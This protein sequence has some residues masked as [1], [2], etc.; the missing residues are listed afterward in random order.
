MAEHAK[1]REPWHKQFMVRIAIIIALLLLLL[2]TCMVQENEPENALLQHLIDARDSFAIPGE[3]VS[4]AAARLETVEAITAFMHEQM[5][6]ATYPERLYTPQDA[7]SLRMASDTDAAVLLYAL[8]SE[9]GHEATLGLSST[10]DTDPTGW[11]TGQPLTDAYQALGDY[12]EADLEDSASATAQ[13]TSAI[14]T[15]QTAMEAGI[16]VA[17]SHSSA[18]GLDLTIA[19]RP[20]A[21]GPRPVVMLEDGRIFRSNGTDITDT[22]DASTITP[23]DPEAVNLL[24]ME[25]WMRTADGRTETLAQWSSSAANNTQ[26]SFQPLTGA[27]TFWAGTFD[28]DTESPALWVPIIQSG[29]EA[30]EGVPFDIGNGAVADLSRSAYA[31]SEPVDVGPAPTVEVWEIASASVHDTGRVSVRLAHDAP[32]GALF[33]AAHLRVDQNGEQVPFRIEAQSA[34]GRPLVI[35]LDRSGSMNDPGRFTRARQAVEALLANLPT[36]TEVGVISFGNESRIE[37]PLQRVEDQTALVEAFAEREIVPYGGNVTSQ[38]IADAQDLVGP[39]AADFVLFNDADADGTAPIPGL[40]AEH[41]SALHSIAL[42]NDA[43]AYNAV[44]TTSRTLAQLGSITRIIDELGDELYGGL[45]LSFAPP[46]AA[47]PQD[48]INFTISLTDDSMFADGQYVM[49]EV[50]ELGLEAIG[51][52]ASLGESGSISTEIARLG[53]RNPLELMMGQHRFIVGTGTPREQHLARRMLDGWIATVSSLEVAEGRGAAMPDADGTMDFDSLAIAGQVRQLTEFAGREGLNHLRGPLMLVHSVQPDFSDPTEL[54][55]TSV[56]NVLSSENS[57]SDRNPYVVGGLWLSE[58]ARGEDLWRAYAALAGAEAATLGGLSVPQR[59]VEAGGTRYSWGWYYSD[60]PAARARVVSQ[61]GQSAYPLFFTGPTNAKG[62]I[63]ARIA[64]EYKDILS[65]LEV[66]GHVASGLGTVYGLPGAPLGGLVGFMTENV[67]QYCHAA[68]HLGFVNEVISGVPT[69]TDDW[70]AYARRECGITDDNSDIA[71][72]YLRE[73][74]SGFAAGQAADWYTLPVG[75]Y[76]AATYGFPAPRNG[77]EGA[78]Q[79]LVDGFF[80][81]S[82]ISVTFSGIIGGVRSKIGQLYGSA[83]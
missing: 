56:L 28:R 69:E 2:A 3:T 64:G 36:G 72:R 77:F 70:G 71:G 80:I 20:R 55:S 59:M 23:W 83:P 76:V 63:A 12:V 26:I 75:N 25:L 35:L 50:P 5:A 39:R 8:L 51:I 11:V 44:S 21:G 32:A 40:L 38:A 1:T 24:A 37:M 18:G 10:L 73:F 43:I 31:Q 48:T 29:T 82:P 78:T 61:W 6:P 33:S 45:R 42:T 19:P 9:A 15:I 27:A 34:A 67:R 81:N 41:G 13:L 52:T 4:Q 49:L 17:Q 57:Y 66:A 53:E 58:Q 30:V 65:N 7:L 60:D 46:A 22:P 74:G 14:T 79:R 47:A 16:T 54:A 62:A 68:V